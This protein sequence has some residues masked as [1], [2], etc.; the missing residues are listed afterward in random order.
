MLET[1]WGRQTWEQIYA[2]P[3]AICVTVGKLLNLSEHPH[4]QDED[5]T[6]RLSGLLGRLHENHYRVLGQPGTQQLP[7]SFL[8]CIPGRSPSALGKPFPSSYSFSGAPVPHLHRQ[9]LLPQ[10]LVRGSTRG[11]GLLSLESAYF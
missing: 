7:V 2:T 10:H 4:L 11:L 9:V 6:A 5:H 3:L 1:P 8:S